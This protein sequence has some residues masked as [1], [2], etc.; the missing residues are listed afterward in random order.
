[1]VRGRKCGLPPV[2]SKWS[3]SAYPRSRIG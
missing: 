3:S 1:L 2:T